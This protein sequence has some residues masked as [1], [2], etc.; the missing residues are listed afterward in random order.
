MECAFV[1]LRLSGRS[2]CHH[3]LCPDRIAVQS[4]MDL[5]PIMRGRDGGPRR[6]KA[7]VAALLI[8][9]P[10][11]S[12][13][14]P[15]LTGKLALLE[16][17]RNEIRAAIPFM[18]GRTGSDANRSISDI[19]LCKRTPVMHQLLFLLKTAGISPEM[20]TWA[21][22]QISELQS[23]NEVNDGAIWNNSS[24]WCR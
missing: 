11:G 13:M 8:L 5:G 4:R 17:L 12:G 22:E 10:A 21:R 2:T 7:F 15:D 23:E 9:R 1:F 24:L 14:T 16:S 18:L 3:G 6:T 20:S 19:P